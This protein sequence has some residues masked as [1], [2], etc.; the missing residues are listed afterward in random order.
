MAADAA[1]VLVSAIWG[2]T[3]FL[4][5]DAVATVPPFWFVAIRFLLA[6]GLVAL[7][8]RT[9]RSLRR[10]AVIAGLWLFSGYALQ[11]FGLGFTSPDQAAFITSLSVLLV[12]WGE[13]LWFHRRPAPRLFLAVLLAALGLWLLLRPSGGLN[14]GD[15]LVL[16]SAFGFAG[17]I[18]ATHGV[19]AADAP[20]FAALELFT[21]GVLATLGLPFSPLP[22]FTPVAL[23]ALGFTALLATALAL[24]VQTWAQS[25]TSPTHAALIFTLE[26]W[27][28]ALASAW[29]AHE[30]LGPAALVGGGLTFLALALAESHGFWRGRTSA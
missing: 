24:V 11:T 10:R 22:R 14:L 2:A 21:V 7:V 26:P 20:G 25:R 29:F 19:N 15:W 27:F 6:A 1:L 8:R 28:A 13:W 23:V 12:P 3:F 9:P 16:G 30:R 18:L 5:R 17:Q 4:I